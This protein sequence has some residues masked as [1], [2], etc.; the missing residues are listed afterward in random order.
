MG[1]GVGTG[2]GDGIGVGVGVRYQDALGKPDDTKFPT[3]GLLLSYKDLFFEFPENRIVELH[4]GIERN[5]DT[6]Y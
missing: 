5:R 6:A 3:V 1:V 4:N 2:E